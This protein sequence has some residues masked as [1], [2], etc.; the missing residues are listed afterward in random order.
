MARYHALI[1]F[2]H[3]DPKTN[4]EI[5]AVCSQILDTNIKDTDKYQVGLTKIFF[6]AGQL[7]YM[8]KLRSD[9]L[10]SCATMIQKNVRRFLARLRYLRVQKMALMLQS[11]AR[12][13]VAVREMELLRR[14]KAAIVI[15]KNWR[16]YIARKKYLQTRAF[17]VQTQAGNVERGSVL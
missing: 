3:W 15:Q 16:R 2:A 13:R 10:N 1:D 11:I 5:R 6:R 4:P 17:I 14:E 12:R 8:E 9:K 7:A